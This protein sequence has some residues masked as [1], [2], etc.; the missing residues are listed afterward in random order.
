MWRITSAPIAT[1]RTVSQAFPR[2]TSAGTHEA[3]NEA[4]GYAGSKTNA[5]KPISPVNTNKQPSN[6]LDD[7]L[8]PDEWL[9]RR[10]AQVYKRA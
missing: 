8:S 3:R 5:P 10:N 1:K 4:F 6:G 9:K 2:P 7:D